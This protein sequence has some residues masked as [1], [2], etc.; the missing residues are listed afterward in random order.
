MK[1]IWAAVS[2]LSHLVQLRQSSCMGKSGIIQLWGS[3]TLSPLK[4]AWC[5]VHAVPGVYCVKLGKMWKYMFYDGIC[6]LACVCQWGFECAG[7]SVRLCGVCAWLVGVRGRCECKGLVG[8]CGRC[9]CVCVWACV[10]G[11]GGCTCEVCVCVRGWWVYVRGACTC[12]CVGG[13]ADS[14]DESTGAPLLLPWLTPG[15][16]EYFKI[17]QL[18]VLLSHSSPRLAHSLC[19]TCLAPSLLPT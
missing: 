4:S 16:Q 19:E 1:I 11:I 3:W 17:R 7:V 9:V 15:C 14:G 13:C 5:M 10:W 18:I 8:V 6:L 2:L 12:A